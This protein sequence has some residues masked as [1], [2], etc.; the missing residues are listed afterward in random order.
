MRKKKNQKISDPVEYMKDVFRLR[1]EIANMLK[2]CGITISAN[3]NNGNENIST[4][5]ERIIPNGAICVQI[6]RN[7]PS[8]I[9][10]PFGKIDIETIP[11]DT[12][13]RKIIAFKEMFANTF[14]TVQLN[15][16]KLSLFD[17][18]VGPWVTIRRLPWKQNRL[19]NYKFETN[20][21]NSSNLKEVIE[22]LYVKANESFVADGTPEYCIEPNI[23]FLSS[24]LQ[25]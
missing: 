11:F 19:P 9:I 4:I 8:K 17:T 7:F 14:Q 15:D 18:Y 24:Y 1:W 22:D 20:L 2:S 25:K 6:S 21:S 13:Y 12:D 23:E 3:I 10:T 16:A 5:G